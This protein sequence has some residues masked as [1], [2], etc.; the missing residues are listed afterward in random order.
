MTKDLYDKAVTYEGPSHYSEEASCAEQ[1]VEKVKHISNNI[2]THF[3]SHE[4]KVISRMVLYFKVD[5]RD[6]VWF[7]YCRSLRVSDRDQ[8]TS[9]P[10]DLT[11]K[12]ISHEQLI[13]TEKDNNTNDEMDNT[14]DFITELTE[15][16]LQYYNMTKEYLFKVNYI[17][18][19]KTKENNGKTHLLSQLDK[20]KKV[21]ATINTKREETAVCNEKE[22]SA[23]DS[24][25]TEFFLKIANDTVHPQEVKESLYNLID[26]YEY[27]SVSFADIFYQAYGNFL[28]PSN[29]SY[30][31]TI[32]TNIID[33]LGKYT[34]LDLMKCTDS[35]QIIANNSEE[36]LEFTVSRIPNATPVIKMGIKMQGLLNSY[37]I[38]LA[39]RIIAGEIMHKIDDNVES[40]LMSVNE[41]NDKLD[42]TNSIYHS[43]KHMVSEHS[44][45]NS[46]ESLDN[47]NKSLKST[48]DSNS[49]DNTTE[50]G[51]LNDSHSTTQS[52]DEP[53]P[54]YSSIKDKLSSVSM[55]P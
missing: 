32:N 46:N 21:Q 6:K 38:K 43:D 51:E 12:F 11:Q 35:E 10:I 27:V 9:M 34:I 22:F 19:R 4:Y 14:G 8:S 45:L 42:D 55:E 28:L 54:D 24:I 1:T 25:N 33:I 53:I 52:V 49:L 26:N 50:L 13:K 36:K 31:F 29:Q 48:G 47:S 23:G 16:D 18:A 20:S 5:A 15:A 2:V 3:Y 37:F 17:S 44:K 7:L 41:Q 30:C 39:E 40:T